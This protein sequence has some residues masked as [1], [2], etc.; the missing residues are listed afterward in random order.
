MLFDN[1]K[2]ILE[3]SSP[4][5]PNFYVTTQYGTVTGLKGANCAHDFYPFFEGISNRT[6]YPVDKKENKRIY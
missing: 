6:Y 2:Y 5:Y 4:E 3:G 1:G